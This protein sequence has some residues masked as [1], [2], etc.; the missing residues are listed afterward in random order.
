MVCMPLP[1]ALCGACAGHAA[2]KGPFDGGDAAL[3]SLP[4]AP[5]CSGDPANVAFG[6]L[7]RMDVALYR[8]F[9]PASFA[10]SLGARPRWQRYGLR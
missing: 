8:R 2:T 1:E 9:D 6:G 5:A 10:R 4:L 7:Y 3:S